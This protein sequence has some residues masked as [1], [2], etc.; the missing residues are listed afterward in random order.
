[1]NDLPRPDHAA[2]ETGSTEPVPQTGAVG[3]VRGR[4]RVLLHDITVFPMLGALMFCSKLLMEWA[5]NVHLLAMFLVAFTVVYRAK[6]LIPLYVFVF[7]TGVYA[8]F[9]LWWLPY[10]YIWLPLWGAAM[11]LPRKMK[12]WIAIPVYM[13]VC[14]LH[15][16][17]YG[18]LYAPA[19]LVL[20][21]LPHHSEHAF[22]ELLAWIALGFPWDVVHA[23]GNLAAGTLVLP[24][25][26]LLLRLEHRK[27]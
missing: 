20:W 14:A 5:P 25:V 9:N 3:R 21:I 17:A 19:Q 1:M 4:S 22:Q 8:G 16:L 13:V 11:L 18:T 12:P 2:P 23:L 26:R 7:L 10:L 27:L 24:L 15:G 6:A